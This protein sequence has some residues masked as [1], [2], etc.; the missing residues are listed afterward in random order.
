ME[1]V[2]ASL[3][4]FVFAQRPNVSDHQWHLY[5]DPLMERT[6]NTANHHQLLTGAW[7]SLNPC[8][9]FVPTA[10]TNSSAEWKKVTAVSQRGVKTAKQPNQD[11]AAV[12]LRLCL[13]PNPDW[14]SGANDGQIHLDLFSVFDGHGIGAAGH[15]CSSFC[16]EIVADLFRALFTAVGERDEVSRILHANDAPM[17]LIELRLQTVLAELPY[18]LDRA[19]CRYLDVYRSRFLAV[20]SSSSA[21]QST[22][23]WSLRGWSRSPQ[24]VPDDQDH[25]D[26][27]WYQSL[28]TVGTT[29]TTVVHWPARN[30]LLV[31]QIGDSPAFL[32]TRFP[33]G[34]AV[35]ALVDEEAHHIDC[36][37]EIARIFA[38]IDSKS[39]LAADY[40]SGLVTLPPDTPDWRL[41]DFLYRYRSDQVPD[42]ELPHVHLKE[43]STGVPVERQVTD[44]AELARIWRLVTRTGDTISELPH[45]PGRYRLLGVHSLSRDIGSVGLRE[46]SH[47]SRAPV[48]P[49]LSLVPRV[50]VRSVDSAR[51]LLLLS[52]DGIHTLYHEFL[53]QQQDPKETLPT[54][55]Q[56]LHLRMLPLIRMPDDDDNNDGSSL[57][58]S[59]SDWTIK[60]NEALYR[61][62]LPTMVPSEGARGQR[63]QP[64]DDVVLVLARLG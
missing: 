35:T 27:K 10:E 20:T 63:L 58:R 59:E 49:L 38:Y 41:S 13:R 39:E 30:R 29:M 12:A 8:P 18:W 44:P 26:D 21:A 52:S 24:S 57:E 1:S 42:A 3:V 53:A 28:L 9:V 5:D 50:T 4:D 22:S 37:A 46:S 34:H 31:C 36:P 15:V 6:L 33:D 14:P 16:A 7:S 40:L 54:L 45:S 32:Y 25:Y 56:W 17:Q 19:W 2:I 51:S 23:R 43:W 47:R 55:E 64:Y 61:L 11:R 62:F 48:K 60:A